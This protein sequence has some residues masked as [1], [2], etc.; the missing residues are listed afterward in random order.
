MFELDLPRQHEL[1]AGT[2]TGCLV[3][4]DA[5]A[6]KTKA[7]ALRLADASLSDGQSGAGNADSVGPERAVAHISEAIRLAA[8]EEPVHGILLACAATDLAEVRVGVAGAFAA[9]GYVDVVNDV[10]GAWG[11]SFGGAD[12]MALISGTGSHAVGVVDGT[13][14]RV[15]GWGHAF[16]DEGS[17]YD[18]GRAAI[19]ASLMAKDGRGAETVLPELLS[20]HFDGLDIAQIVARLY[21]SENIKADTADLAQV[22]DAAARKGDAVATQIVEQAAA[23]LVAHVVALS[24]MLPVP[25]RAS[26]G[27]VGSTWKSDAL[28]DSFRAALAEQDGVAATLQAVRIEREPVDGVLAL[29]LGSV[30]LSSMRSA[31]GW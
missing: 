25:E 3:A 1:P 31:L 2:S 19:T 5:G 10:I 13:A 24:T 23:A 9:S 4:V 12:G 27:L 29:L 18:L 15:G 11:S 22:L 30:G 26:V 14:V 21:R 8:G 16:G 7:R 20:E 28:T 17:A 6:T